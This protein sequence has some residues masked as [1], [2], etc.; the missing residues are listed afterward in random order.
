M[1]KTMSTQPMNISLKVVAMIL[2][3]MLEFK[4]LICIAKILSMWLSKKPVNCF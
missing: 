1:R 4:R 3:V 2:M